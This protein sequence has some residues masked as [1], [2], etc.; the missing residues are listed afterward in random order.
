MT[1]TVKIECIVST[2]TPAD[3]SKAPFKV[4]HTFDK[5]GRKMRVKFR[6]EI[7]DTP[8]E[9]ALLTVRGSVQTGGKYGAVLWVSEIV[10]TE[11]LEEIYADNIG[12]YFGD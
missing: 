4:Y 8:D 2:V 5:R 12:E 1:D 10:S 9:N 7:K 6:K 3:K 11:K